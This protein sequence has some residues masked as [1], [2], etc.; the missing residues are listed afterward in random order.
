MYV[1]RRARFD[2]N[3]RSRLCNEGSDP[4]LL[5]PQGLT[6]AMQEPG[7]F[8]LSADSVWTES[9]DHTDALAA[10]GTIDG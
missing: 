1:G 8:E 7:D 10:M 9:S 2:S 3:S 5:A 6:L 4:S